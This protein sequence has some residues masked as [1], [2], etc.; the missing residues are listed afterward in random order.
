MNI[1]SRWLYATRTGIN[2]MITKCLKNWIRGIDMDED[3]KSLRDSF[4]MKTG[5]MI[6][7]N[8]S[9][10]LDLMKYCEFL[11]DKLYSSV[12]YAKKLF[13]VLEDL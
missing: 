9:G 8:K 1:R 5:I 7:T 2:S 12:F 3:E 11:E 10:K 6:D 13:N 4:L